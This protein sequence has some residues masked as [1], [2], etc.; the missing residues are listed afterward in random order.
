MLSRDLGQK[1]TQNGW[2]I[3]W[4]STKPLAVIE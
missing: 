4:K 2:K 1:L 3:R